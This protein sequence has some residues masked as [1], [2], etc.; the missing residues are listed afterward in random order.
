M[1][2]CKTALFWKHA[3]IYPN[4]NLYPFSHKRTLLIA[5]LWLHM[6]THYIVEYPLTELVVLTF[7]FLRL[8]LF[9]SNL[10][11]G[12][13]KLLGSTLDFQVSGQ[14]A[15]LYTIGPAAQHTLAIVELCILIEALD[16]HSVTAW[17]LLGSARSDEQTAAYWAHG[18]AL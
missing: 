6:F 2:K 14:L 9:L 1:E 7:L 13:I 4:G 10:I 17:K 12:L 18:T 15:W 3:L 5:F 16:A 8:F 11:I